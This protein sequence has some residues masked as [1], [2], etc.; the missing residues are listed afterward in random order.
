VLVGDLGAHGGDDD[1][2][3][4]HREEAHEGDGDLGAARAAEHLV[5]R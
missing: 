2:G 5:T 3:L 4:G 1:D